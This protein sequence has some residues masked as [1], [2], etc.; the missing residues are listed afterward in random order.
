MDTEPEAARGE[1]YRQEL[2]AAGRCTRR[3]ACRCCEL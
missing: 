2:V 3:L 1:D